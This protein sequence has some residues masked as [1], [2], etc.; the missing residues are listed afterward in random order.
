MK[1][2]FLLTI[3]MG[4]IAVPSFSQNVGIFDQTADWGADPNDAADLHAEGSASFENG[5]YTVMGNGDDIWGNVDEGFY[6]YTEKSGSWSLKA[7]AQWIDSGAGDVWSKIGVMIRE[8]GDAN[9]SSNYMIRQ[10]GNL[11]DPDELSTQWRRQTGGELSESSASFLDSSGN[12]IVDPDEQGVW[13]RISRNADTDVLAAEWSPDGNSWS[14]M[15][16]IHIP[17][18]DSVAYGLAITSHFNDDVLVTGQFSGVELTEGAPLTVFR[19]LPDGRV[20]AGD[21]ITVKL[22]VGNGTGSNKSTT[23]VETVPSG[24]TVSNISNGGALSGDTITW[25]L[26]APN[27]LTDLTYTAVGASSADLNWSGTFDGSATLGDTTPVYLR[28]RTPKVASWN[29]PT[30]G[31]L[32]LFDPDLGSSPNME[33]EGWSHNNGSDAY[34]F[35]PV[36]PA[37]PNQGKVWHDPGLIDDEEGG[38]ALLIYDPGDPRSMDQYGSIPDPGNRKITMSYDLGPVTK[39]VASFRV[40]SKA[41]TDE[42]GVDIP[43]GY[44][45]NEGYNLLGLMINREMRDLTL[46]EELTASGLFFSPEFPDSLE[47]PTY[48]AYPGHAVPGQ[49]EEPWDHTQWHEYWIRWNVTEGEKSTSLYVDGELQ[50]KFAFP[51]DPNDEI[52]QQGGFFNRVREAEG[53]IPIGNAVFRITFRQTGGAGNLQ[54]D[55]ITFAPGVDEAPTAYVNVND[56]AL[57]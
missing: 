51:M 43:F 11:G 55:Y 17:M 2:F 13:M 50:A 31:W 20:T 19:D 7:K 56:W 16:A 33:L 45:E 32:Y 30:G 46:I 37:G 18:A 49:Y 42:F 35:Q 40:R 53:G 22:Q 34:V 48:S 3:I 44:S 1:R 14:L 23:I 4:M 6:V 38:Q 25:N 5:V 26:D 41:F 15:D 47:F 24:W 12:P 39:A 27:G 10:R 9:N 36:I 52:E 8:I 57:Y 28:G 54:F 21:S 29:P